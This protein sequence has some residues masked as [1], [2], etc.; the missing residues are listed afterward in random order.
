[1]WIKSAFNCHLSDLSMSPE[2]PDAH[3]SRRGVRLEQLAEVTVS[4]LWVLP[5]PT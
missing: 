4:Q 3:S 2:E 1:M 5:E